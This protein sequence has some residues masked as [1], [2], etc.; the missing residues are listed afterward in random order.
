[1]WDMNIDLTSLYH[2]SQAKDHPCDQSY[3]TI[4]LGGNPLETLEHKG[5]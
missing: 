3:S 5:N 4:H 2:I 1:M